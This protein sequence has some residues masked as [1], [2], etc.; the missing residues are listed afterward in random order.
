MKSLV[1]RPLRRVFARAQFR[2]SLRRCQQANARK[3]ASLRLVST[4]QKCKRDFLSAGA[5]GGGDL[6]GH[7]PHPPRAVERAAVSQCFVV[8]ECAS[9]SPCAV[10]RLPCA[11]P[12]PGARAGAVVLPVRA[13]ARA[14]A[15]SASSRG[16]GGKRDRLEVVVVDLERDAALQLA[17]ED[18]PCERSSSR[19]LP[20]ASRRSY[21]A[22]ADRFA[23]ADLAGGA[24]CMRP[25]RDART[26]RRALEN[27]R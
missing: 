4:G 3:H 20:A 6:T 16:V 7:V 1:G 18:E 25:P 5:I 9:A 26:R 2:R 15:R 22:S 11:P 13:R 14:R 24:R 21:G 12:P 27:A 8:H 17:D 10:D 23:P 19:R